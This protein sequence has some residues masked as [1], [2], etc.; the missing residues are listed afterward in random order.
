MDSGNSPP[1]PQ[2]NRGKKK[3]RRLSSAA[4]FIG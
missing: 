1:A 2:E 3:A 4:P